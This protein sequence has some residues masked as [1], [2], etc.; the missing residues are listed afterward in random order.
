MKELLILGAGGMGKEVYSIAK[1]SI[2]YGTDFVIKGFL[3]FPNDNWDDTLPPIISI[4]DE[5]VIQPNDIFVCSIG[6][7]KLKRKICEKMENRGAVFYTLIHK[8]AEIRDNVK[9]GRGCIIDCYTVVGF[10]A[11]IGKQCLIQNHAI[12]AHGVPIGDYSRIDCQ[13][14][15]VGDV[16]VGN[17]CTIHTASVVN[18][19]V[20]IEDEA[21]VGAC[22]FVIKNVKHGTT[23]YGNPARE[24][25]F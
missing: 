21:I 7:I 6:D 16:Q 20:K 13:V 10:G 5:Y 24:L 12:I 23:V 9:I 11:Q 17:S 22:S 8:N 3:D 25:K 15:L 18:H 1:Q 14:M 19:H 2:G 4:E